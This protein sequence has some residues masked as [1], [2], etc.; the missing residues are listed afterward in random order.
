MSKLQGPSDRKNSLASNGST[1]RSTYPFGSNLAA[2]CTLRLT[3]FLGLPCSLLSPRNEYRSPE[4]FRPSD[5]SD[6]QTSGDAPLRQ[7]EQPV[8]DRSCSSPSCRIFSQRST[9][10]L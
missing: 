6:R 5:R 1:Q 9:E 2:L 8:F 10:P 4:P 3:S 7:S